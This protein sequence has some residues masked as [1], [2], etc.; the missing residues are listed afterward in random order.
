MGINAL[1]GAGSAIIL[2]LILYA[3]YGKNHVTNTERPWNTFISKITDNESE[4][5]RAVTVF[6]ASDL[7]NNN[8]LNLREFTAAIRALEWLPNEKDIIRDFFHLLDENNDG[9]L[10][11]DEFLMVIRTMSA[12]EE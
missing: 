3:S 11:I 10:D 12:E 2:G 1:I 9:V 8:H 4:L 6:R 5:M 7:E